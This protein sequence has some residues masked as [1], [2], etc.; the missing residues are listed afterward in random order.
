MTA[1][2]KLSAGLLLYRAHGETVEVLL[3]HPG[4]PFFARKDA[5]AW[6]L[7]KGEPEP[8]EQ[9]LACAIRE[10]AEETGVRPEAAQYV[11]LGK[12]KQRG[13]KEVHAWAF[14]MAWT[15]SGAPQ[16][17]TFRIEWPPRSGRMQEF[18]EI[19]RLELFE[20]SAAREKM[21]PAQVVFLDRLL[22]YLTRAK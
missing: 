14:E 2:K 19:D 8:G 12:V 4:G 6:T 3:A 10:F 18:P 9:E 22:E 17:N 13:G 7:P 15:G 20:L 1:S 21:N 16:S 5:G 11:D